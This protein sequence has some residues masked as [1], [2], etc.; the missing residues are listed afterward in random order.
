MRKVKSYAITR[1]GSIHRQNTKTRFNK[2][3]ESKINFLITITKLEQLH[4]IRKEI[5]KN[6]CAKRIKVERSRALDP[7]EIKWKLKS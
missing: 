7:F 4:N 2:N 3:T 5:N 6:K 1:R